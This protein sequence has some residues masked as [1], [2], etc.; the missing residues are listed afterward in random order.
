MRNTKTTDVHVYACTL[1]HMGA[2][3]EEIQRNWEVMF[4]RYK[5]AHVQPQARCSVL[6]GGTRVQWEK[7]RQALDPSK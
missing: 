5:G 1:M 3:I 2:L 7:H 4:Q 6:L